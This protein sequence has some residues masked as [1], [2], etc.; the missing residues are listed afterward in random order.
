MVYM[1]SI[2]LSPNGLNRTKEIVD[3]FLHVQDDTEVIFERGIYD[4]YRE[5]SY[6]GYFFPCCNQNGEKQVIFPI[7]NRKNIVI[8]EHFNIIPMKKETL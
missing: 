5:G 7:L 6:N 2:K 4:F 8:E 1:K 3:L